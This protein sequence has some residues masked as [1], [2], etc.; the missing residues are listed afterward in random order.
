MRMKLVGTL[1]LTLAVAVVAAGITSTAFGTT[2]RAGNLILTLNGD[3]LP[4]KLPA[5]R[6]APIKLKASGAIR[7]ADGSQPP[8]QQRLF[9]EFD[10]N[11]TVFNNGLPSCSQRQLENR[12]T[13]QADRVC[14][15]AR[16]GTGRG[17]ASVEFPDQAPFNAA[18]PIRI[19]NG[20]GRGARKSIMV[21]TYVAIP[22]P[23]A[24]VIP[25]R[26]NTR[27]R[28]GRYGTSV[29]L[30]IPLIAGGFGSITKFDTT[31]V[32]FF[33]FRGRK[34]S[35]LY[36]RCRDGRFRARGTLTFRDRTS[37]KGTV[38]RPCRRRR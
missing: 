15:R 34:R 18:G 8:A 37:I 28:G 35:Y 1:A 12:T 4:R 23:T 21:H 6:F 22:A 3:A 2:V 19:Y 27:Y 16:I 20:P 10:R 29:D 17:V 9:L 38:V 33:R 36:A 7:T 11:G 26:L 13:R 5:K 25:G 24:I 32:R 14:G 31:T 30:R